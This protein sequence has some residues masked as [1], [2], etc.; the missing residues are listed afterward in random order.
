ML[1]KNQQIDEVLNLDVPF[2]TI[3]SRL[4]GRWTHLASGR[5]YNVDFNPPKV[6]VSSIEM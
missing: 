2:E 3:H 4:A 1:L 6:D 5:V